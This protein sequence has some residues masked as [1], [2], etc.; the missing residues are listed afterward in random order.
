M[1][2]ADDLEPVCVALRKLHSVRRRALAAL[3][4]IERDIRTLEAEVRCPDPRPETCVS[5]GEPCDRAGIPCVPVR[6]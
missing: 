2:E 5:R 1:S 3:E 4:A 6:S